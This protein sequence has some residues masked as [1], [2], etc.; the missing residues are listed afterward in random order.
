MN[1]AHYV[2]HVALSSPPAERE[3][4]WF[5]FFWLSAILPKRPRN[6]RCKGARADAVAL[7]RSLKST[8]ADTRWHKRAENKTHTHTFTRKCVCVCN[9]L[10]WV[11]LE[12]HHHHHW[13]SLR[14]A[15]E[16][17]A[18][19][20]TMKKGLSIEGGGATPQGLRNG[21]WAPCWMGFIRL[22]GIYYYGLNHIGYI[23]IDFFIII[24]SHT[25]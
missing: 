4:V 6:E 15:L 8:L 16:S 23:K 2:L 12:L 11:F 1:L 17:V 20:F 13:E 24:I 5:V 7:A 18:S 10:K 3:N 21:E 9:M 22:L 19:Q 14:H 25:M